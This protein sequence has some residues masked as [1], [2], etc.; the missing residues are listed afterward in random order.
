MPQHITVVSYDPVWNLKFKDEKQKIEAI[1]KNDCFGVFHIG[2]TSVKNL[3]AKPIIDIL[4]VVRDLS[5][6]DAKQ[7][8]FENLGYEYL[9]EFGIKG[10]RYLR[11]GGDERTHQIHVF[12]HDNLDEII[13]HLAFRDYLRTHKDVCT[14]YAKLKKDL[15]DKFPYDINGYCDGKDNFVK[16]HEQKALAWYDSSWDR[17]YFAAR[18]IQTKRDVSPFI[19]AGPVAAALMTVKGNIYTGVCIDT[20]CSLGMCAER[21]AISTMITNG[22][23]EI[24]KILALKADGEIIMPCGS[25]R[26]LMMQ[27]SKDSPNIE[28]LIDYESR[29][30]VVL[31]TLIPNWWGKDQF[32]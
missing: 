1:L 22:E 4:V 26:E 25:C 28:V 19:V 23:S 12:K 2:S 14:E 13:R 5:L 24:T 15:A 32:S 3:D 7:T 8:E 18:S 11:K 9:G 27:L 29:A 30:A 16:E 6:V 20:A 21:N 17:L 10:R 31:G